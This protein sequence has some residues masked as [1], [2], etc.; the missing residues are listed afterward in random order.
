[1]GGLLHKV[2]LQVR[3]RR[4]TV[5]AK[6]KTDDKYNCLALEWNEEIN[7][8]GGTGATIVTRICGHI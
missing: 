3:F 8:Y 2:R 5:S 4:C 6:V 1:M 7:M